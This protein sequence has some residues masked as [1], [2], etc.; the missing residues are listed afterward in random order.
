MQSVWASRRGAFV[1]GSLRNGLNGVSSHPGK[2]LRIATI[3]S[4]DL[5]L[6]AVS[7]KMKVVEGSGIDILILNWS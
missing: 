1:Q 6:T 2:Y 3:A 5:L 7:R 4:R